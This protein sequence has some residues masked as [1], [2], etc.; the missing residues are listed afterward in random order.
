MRMGGKTDNQGMPKRLRD[1]L[2]QTIFNLPQASMEH[3][4]TRKAVMVYLIVLVGV[5]TSFGLGIIIWQEGS[6]L[7]AQFDFGLGLFL[8]GLF[9]YVRLSGNTRN[10]SIAGT[11]V[12]MLFYLILFATG[13]AHQQSFIWYY[14][15]PLITLFL[16]G[17]PVGTIFNL[18]LISLT[19]AI[20]SFQDYLSFFKPYPEGLVLRIVI[21]YMMVFIFTLVFEHTR[22]TTRR[23]LEKAMKELGELA[24]RDGLT[25]LYNR[26]Y[27]DEV[28]AR[29]VKQLNRSGSTVAFLMADLDFFKDYNDAY[30]HTAGDEALNSFAAVLSALV[31]RE[32][33]N[34]FRYGGEEFAMLLSP[35]NRRTAEEFA[36]QIIEDTRELNILHERSPL[37]RLSVSV[38]VALVDITPDTTFQDLM[39]TA[40]AALYEAKAEGRDRFVLRSDLNSALV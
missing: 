35:T 39:D 1:F 11:L 2:K 29:V 22:Q 36:R 13:A 37:G 19:L 7:L 6:Y 31:R 33:D 10:G 8:A 18:T 3:E 15:Y 4:E 28:V 14:V 21:S 24:I 9:L 20:W 38:G 12:I 16:L 32:T 5:L 23:K 34:V 25:G 27:F 30:G 26:R 17:I 40:D